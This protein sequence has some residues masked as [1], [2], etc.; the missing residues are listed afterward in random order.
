MRINKDLCDSPDPSKEFDRAR[1]RQYTCSLFSIFILY[2]RLLKA[3]NAASVEGQSDVQ[4]RLEAIE[5]EETVR[6]HLTALKREE[7][8]LQ[9]S[10]KEINIFRNLALYIWQFLKARKYIFGRCRC[11]SFE[12]CF[13]LVSIFALSPPPHARH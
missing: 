3:S 13:V 2:P 1:Y 5:E 9:A 12:S 11:P 4:A 6:M 8:A 10:V 7:I